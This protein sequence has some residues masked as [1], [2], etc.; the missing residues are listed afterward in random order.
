MTTRLALLG[1]LGAADSAG[2]MLAGAGAPGWHG[3]AAADYEDGRVRTAGAVA[4]LADAIRALTGL[5]GELGEL[6]TV[7][8]LGEV[9]AR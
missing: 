4:G 7:P 3:T 6:A 5:C 8:S 2:D 9:S 1:A